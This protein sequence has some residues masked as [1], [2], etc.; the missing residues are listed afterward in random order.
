M[1][2]KL[3]SSTNILSITNANSPTASRLGVFFF[4]SCVSCLFRFLESLRAVLLEGFRMSFFA[5]RLT[6]FGSDSMG[7]PPGCLY[8]SLVPGSPISACVCVLLRDLAWPICGAVY[9][10]LRSFWPNLRLFLS[11]SFN[12]LA[13]LPSEI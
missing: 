2:W 9:T 8:T 6:F 1:H 5:A 7:S 11:I 12:L 13:L 10:V 3:S 4:F